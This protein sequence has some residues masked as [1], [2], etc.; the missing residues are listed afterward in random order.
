VIVSGIRAFT[1]ATALLATIASTL[2]VYPHQLA[3]FNELAGGPENGHRHLLHSN[4]DWGQDLLLVKEWCRSHGRHQPLFMALR[5]PYA[6]LILGFS[7]PC[8]PFADVDRIDRNNPDA[9]PAYHIVSN[10]YLAHYSDV[11]RHFATPHYIDAIGR[12]HYVYA[13]PVSTQRQPE[14]FTP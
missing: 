9:L 11:Y 1:I 10:A 7:N 8:S 14:G 4:L 12:V 3:Y 13:S 5:A 6:G 2:R